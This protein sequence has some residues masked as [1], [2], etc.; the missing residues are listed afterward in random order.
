MHHW[1]LF[2]SESKRERKYS[3]RSILTMRGT[4]IDSWQIKLDERYRDRLF[5]LVSRPC[6]ADKTHRW[7]IVFVLEFPHALVFVTKLS[8]RTKRCGRCSRGI[9]FDQR[10]N[11]T[12]NNDRTFHMLERKLMR[13]TSSKK[14]ELQG[15]EQLQLIIT[16][17]FQRIN[18]SLISFITLLALNCHLLK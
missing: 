12:E 6:F 2:P 17:T 15:Q 8:F 1:I 5:S 13:A 16:S 14:E 9:Y 18:V 7:D 4:K 3:W 11:S 10:N